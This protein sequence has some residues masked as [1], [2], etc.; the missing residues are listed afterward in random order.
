MTVFVLDAILKVTLALGAAALLT[1]VW[2]RAPA[3]RRHFVWVLALGAALALPAVKWAGPEWPV[4]PWP[5]RSPQVD[6]TG[7]ATRQDASFSAAQPREAAAAPAARTQDIAARSPAPAALPGEPSRSGGLPLG[8][9][10]ATGWLA[11]ALVVL[12]GLAIG[13]RRVAR[14]AARATPATSNDWRDLLTT[15][16]GAL[17]LRREVTLLTAPGPTMPMTW[18]TRRPV[19]LLPAGV[20]TWSA[21]RRRYV[22]LHE[23]AHVQRR[24][25]L[26]QLMALVA[27]ALYWFH[28]LVWLAAARLRIERER[29][30]DDLVLMA[31]S[32][33]SAY[34]THLL[35]IARALRPAGA[36]ALA[37]LAMARPSH[38]AGRVRAVLDAAR[39]RGRLTRRVVLPGSVAAALLVLPL[40][41]ARPVHGAA[42]AAISAA[43]TAAA[44]ANAPPAPVPSRVRP[45]AVSVR[46]DTGWCS[47]DRSDSRSTNSTSNGRH[48]EVRYRD[49]RCV[50]EL[51]A[52]G[53]F[54]F[55]ADF[56]DIDSIAAGGWVTLER[57][58]EV[59]QRVTMRPGAGGTVA[60]RWFVG[61]DERPYDA[62][63]RAWL[64]ATL[65]DLFRHTGYKAKARSRRVLETRGVE[66]MFA[67]IA[68][69]EG[70]YARR[71]YYQ[72]LVAEGHLDPPTVTRVVTQAGQE[73][74][75]D[76]DL[77]ELLVLVARQYRLDEPTRAAF[78]KAV[79]QIESD[80]DRRRVLGVVLA[81]PDLSDDLA[82]AILGAAGG[83][84]SDYDLSEVLV[85]L[86]HKHPITAGMSAAFF[87]AVDGIE[88]DYDRRRVLATLLARDDLTSDQ[89]AGA[90][91]AAGAISSDYDRAEIL[92]QVADGS[93]IDDRLRGPFFVAADGI[94]SD[95]DHARVLTAV[96]SRADVAGPVVDAVIGSTRGINSDYD[97]AEVLVRVVR[98]G[99]LTADQRRAFMAAAQEIG[100]E[101]DRT[102][103]LAAL[104]Q[105]TPL[106]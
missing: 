77:A 33:P 51:V 81:G 19:V 94:G 11:G 53:D 34:A 88:S 71:I 44:S 106:D 60:H 20:L 31:G 80:Y 38:L 103:V 43:V 7:L 82:S 62:T 9:W 64:A 87:K 17:G 61:N 65:T 79:G 26:T 52:E 15:L 55:T 97:R 69:L 75:S 36:T 6:P 49:G 101:Y 42:P 16:T 59:T 57:R 89:V 12:S 70:D 46:A 90:V 35:D 40:A 93:T 10:L 98:S 67:E 68:Q 85:V 22:L 78:V 8:A 4:L 96:V 13:R 74:S 83:I 56:T 73:I 32:R 14:L 72:A 41:A 5:A 66:G 24:D 1:L 54:G 2:R 18:G 39:R 58:A 100:S 30:C 47:G 91:R 45:A 50:T 21:E 86:V 105:A 84:Q 3:A 28:P 92:V 48:V 27:C 76:Y 63:A 95:Y 102:R 29:A 37:G 25:C 99:S 104:A 23:L